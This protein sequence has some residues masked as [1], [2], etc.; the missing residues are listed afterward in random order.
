MDLDLVTSRELS[1]EI[2]KLG[3]KKPSTWYWVNYKGIGE[4]WDVCLNCHVELKREHYPAYTV[5]ELEKILPV[6]IRTIKRDRLGDKVDYETSG[7]LYRYNKERDCREWLRLETQ[8]GNIGAESRGKM[9][10]YIL[11]NRL[12]E[13]EDLWKA[14]IKPILKSARS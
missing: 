5:G 4:G 13:V 12:M 1:E 14:V 7:L 9:L 3:F 11:K 2:H 8:Y 6:G 10:A